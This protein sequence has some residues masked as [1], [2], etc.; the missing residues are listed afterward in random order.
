MKTTKL[1]ILCLVFT[2]MFVGKTYATSISSIPS[3]MSAPVVLYDEANNVLTDG[4]YTVTIRLSDLTGTTMYAE[5]QEVT[6]EKG[7]A[8]ITIGQGYAVGSGQSSPAGGLS[9]SVFSYQG[10]ISVEILVDGQANTQEITVFGSQPYA[11]IS[12]RALTVADDAITSDKIKDGTITEDDL[13]EGLVDKILGASGSSGSGSTTSGTTIVDAKNVSVS[14]SIG[15]NNASGSN[16]HDVLRG[17]DTSIDLLRETHLDQSISSVETSVTN[18]NTTISNLDSTYATDAQLSSSVSSL[19]SQISQNASDIN[20]LQEQ[21]GTLDGD[22][23]VEDVP[24]MIRPVAYGYMESSNQCENMTLVSAYNVSSIT[25]SHSSV[26]LHFEDSIAPKGT[27]IIITDDVS[28]PSAQPDRDHRCIRGKGK[29]SMS[30]SSINMLSAA[31]SCSDSAD[32]NSIN[33]R[34]VSFM[35]YL[36]PN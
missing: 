10:D 12:Q 18:I 13:D 31:I 26:T 33:E 2:L 14:T 25:P 3:I 23:D 21:V 32:C 5:E 27:L 16:V 19:S 35:I 30:G 29:Y 22:V 4:E 28:N 1:I 24:V 34:A 20:E 6:V 7:V 15:L 9:W 36:I 17:L 11:F 8:Y